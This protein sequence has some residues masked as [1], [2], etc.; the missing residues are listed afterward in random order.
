MMPVEF[1]IRGAL[2]T[3]KEKRE[4][5]SSLSFSLC[6]KL[7]ND[8]LQAKMQIKRSSKRGDTK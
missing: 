8:R 1:A 6:R 3:L 5:F 2:V 4:A 7:Q